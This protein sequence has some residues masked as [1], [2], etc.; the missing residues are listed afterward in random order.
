MREIVHIQAGQ[1]GNQI[2]AK[3]FIYIFFSYFKV[4]YFFVVCS[5]RCQQRDCKIFLLIHKLLSYVFTRNLL[6]KC[7]FERFKFHC[8]ATVLF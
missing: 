6:L 3:V 5:P 4:I 1:C 2:G 8:S 7:L